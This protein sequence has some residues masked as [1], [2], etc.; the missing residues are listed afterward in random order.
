MEISK[1][2]E[3]VKRVEGELKSHNQGMETLMVERADLIHQVM[4]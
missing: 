4:H 3:E 2:K 1:L